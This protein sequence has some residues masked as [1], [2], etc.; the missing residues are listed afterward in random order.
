MNNLI[1]DGQ[2]S[3]D[4]VLVQHLRCSKPDELR[5][6]RVFEIWTQQNRLYF[7]DHEVCNMSYVLSLFSIIE[8]ASYHSWLFRKWNGINSY[9]HAFKYDRGTIR[10]E[11][12]CMS[13]TT[14]LRNIT[15][16]DLSENKLKNIEQV[17]FIV[18]ERCFV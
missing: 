11:Q 15:Y 18:M 4:L 8:Y 1:D 12:N 7:D 5:G 14:Y 9:L 2:L 13:M 17:V 6:L 16:L 10:Q 3:E